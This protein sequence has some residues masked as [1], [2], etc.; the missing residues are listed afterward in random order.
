MREN[1]RAPQLRSRRMRMQHGSLALVSRK[2]GPGVWQFRWSEKDLHGS[3]VQRKRVLGTVE[4]HGPSRLLFGLY[5]IISGDG[6]LNRSWR[7]AWSPRSGTP[8]GTLAAF[9]TLKLCDALGPGSGAESAVLRGKPKFRAACGR[10]NSRGQPVDRCRS[11]G[12][13]LA[14]W[15]GRH[16]PARDRPRCSTRGIRGAPTH[17]PKHRIE[18]SYRR[19]A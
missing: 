14:P 4:T 11:A 5:G 18:L 7:S 12:C 2:E 15:N 19:R 3:R 16:G 9:S 10:A 13:W 17:R 6:T 8:S 1:P